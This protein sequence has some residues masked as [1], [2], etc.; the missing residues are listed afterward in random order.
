MTRR[1]W[2]V[3]T[4]GCP[5]AAA[6]N[7]QELSV[8]VDSSNLLRVSAPGLH[9][10]S[11]RSLERLKDGATVAFLGQV[12]LSTDAN[13]TVAARAAAR[14]AL[15]YDIWEERLSVTRFT[16]ARNEVV[17]RS[18]SHLSPR[19][20]EA[21]CL[22]QLTLDPSLIPADR[23]VWIRFEVRV[24]SEREGA[25]VIGEPG[26]N[27]TRLI[28]LFSRPTRAQQQRWQLDAGPVRLADLRGRT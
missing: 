1:S 5:V 18:A 11:G 26:I 23:P 2:L 20:A 9:F 10:L 28:E 3:A 25:Q 15:S 12:T 7:A 4:L 6:L 22:D 19:A 16:I 24:D 27:I 17:T 14:F 8:R 13:T 21:W